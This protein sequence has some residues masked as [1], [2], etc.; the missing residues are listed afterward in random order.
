MDLIAVDLSVGPLEKQTL[1]Q[2]YCPSLG[3]SDVEITDRL[4]FIRKVYALLL[5]QLIF[6][7]VTVALVC[8]VDALREGIKSTKW[9]VFLLM[10]LSIAIIVVVSCWTSWARRHPRNLIM[11]LS[12]VLRN[13]DDLRSVCGGVVLLLFRP[14]RCVGGSADDFRSVQRTDYICILRRI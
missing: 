10:A 7:I 12:F 13:V 14:V 3:K 5:M 9:L 6:T 1:L 2:R 11:L 8:G 4:K